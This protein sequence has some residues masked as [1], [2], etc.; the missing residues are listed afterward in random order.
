[1]PQTLYKQPSEVRRYTMDCS[2]RLAALDT[3]ASVTSVTEQTVDQET[4]A[5]TSSTDLTI[6]AASISGQSIQVQISG[7]SEGVLYLITFVF[8]NGIVE[9]VE[10]EGFLFVRDN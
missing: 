5:R 6:G 2:P 8:V 3:I 10:A 4:G 9:T 7:G 1:M